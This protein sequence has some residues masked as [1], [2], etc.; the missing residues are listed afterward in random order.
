MIPQ[1][2]GSSFSFFYA[3]KNNVSLLFRI[4]NFNIH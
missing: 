3:W 4:E 2:E 1:T